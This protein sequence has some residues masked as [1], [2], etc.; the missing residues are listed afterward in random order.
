MAARLR[1]QLNAVRAADCCSRAAYKVS[2]SGII[3]RN[4]L[5]KSCPIVARRGFCQTQF[6]IERRK[7]QRESTEPKA[8][9]ES[10]E[11]SSEAAEI[12]RLAGCASPLKFLEGV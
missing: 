3:W 1:A 2:I 6:T 4:D 12:Y 8:G 9:C 11:K 7:L 5:P 10:A